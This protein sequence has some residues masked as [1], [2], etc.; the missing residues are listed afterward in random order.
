MDSIHIY[1]YILDSEQII[2]GLRLTTVCLSGCH[3]WRISPGQYISYSC[4]II[5]MSLQIVTHRLQE[6][7]IHL[8]AASR[9]LSPMYLCPK[10]LTTEVVFSDANWESLLQAWNVVF[11]AR[12]GISLLPHAFL[13]PLLNNGCL[14]CCVWGK[15]LQEQS[16]LARLDDSTPKCWWALKH[17]FSKALYIP[18]CIVA[19]LS[20]AHHHHAPTLPPLSSMKCNCWG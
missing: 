13:H 19:G 2:W 12:K 14:H 11:L 7:F 9:L 20:Q 16:H 4:L 8:N 1:S 3:S 18:L 5:Y 15:E 17:T 6:V 10:Q